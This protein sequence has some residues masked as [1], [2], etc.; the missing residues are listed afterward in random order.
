MKSIKCV[1]L[2]TTALFLDLVVNLYGSSSGACLGIYKELDTLYL[3]DK[4][5]L[6]TAYL[7]PGLRQY[8]NDYLGFS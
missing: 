3:P 1:I 5:V 4:S 6:N 7:E 2:W 8:R